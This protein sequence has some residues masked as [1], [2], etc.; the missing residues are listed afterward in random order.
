M[1]TTPGD[2]RTGRPELVWGHSSRRDLHG[3]LLCLFVGR[4]AWIF[5]WYGRRDLKGATPTPLWIIAQPERVRE[6]QRIV[7][8][9]CVEVHAAAVPDRIRLY[10]PPQCGRIHPSPVVVHSPL[11][12]PVLPAVSESNRRPVKRNVPVVVL[13]FSPKGRYAVLVSA[14]LPESSVASTDPWMSGMNVARVPVTTF[15]WFN[16]ASGPSPYA[17]HRDTW[18][19]VPSYSNTSR[20]S[21]SVT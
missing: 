10:E 13:V 17:Y 8:N 15:I 12:S 6:V 18:P 21:A 9:I 4:H 19:L 20:L 14:P 2:P 11:G 7:M 3:S 5:A 1:G 16:T